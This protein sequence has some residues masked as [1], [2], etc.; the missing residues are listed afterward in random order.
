MKVGEWWV[1]KGVLTTSVDPTRDLEYAGEQFPDEYVPTVFMT[2][3]GHR[4]PP[5]AWTARHPWDDFFRNL[6]KENLICCHVEK[7]ADAVT[8][9][10]VPVAFAPVYRNGKVFG[11]EPDVFKRIRDIIQRIWTLRSQLQM[12]GSLSKSDIAGITG[13]MVVVGRE[14][15]LDGEA[16]IAEH[17]GQRARTSQSDPVP[18]REVPELDDLFK[19][20]NQNAM[21]LRTKVH[22][23]VGKT[24]QRRMDAY[25]GHFHLITC[26]DAHMINTTDGGLVYP[27]L[28]TFVNPPTGTFGIA[29]EHHGK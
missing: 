8:Q 1:E 24:I 4:E 2:G 12:N 10:C 23:V 17:L 18:S 27:P 26:G 22:N 21:A 9:D 15:Y 14:G 19:I 11:W 6:V 13:R 3:D 7:F 28:Y 25:P 29:D 5:F 16:A 20:Y